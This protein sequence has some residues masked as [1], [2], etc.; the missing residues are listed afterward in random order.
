MTTNTQVNKAITST[1]TAGAIPLWDANLNLSANNYL[2]GYTTTATAAGTTTLTIASTYQQFFTGSTT[3]TVTLPVTSTLVLG[4]SF[5]IVNNSSGNV[6]VNSSGGNAIQVMGANTTLLVT[7]ILTSG[8]T[9]ASWSIEYVGE[10]SG[11]TVGSGTIN[12]LA[13]YSATGTTV[14]GLTIVNSAGL[15]TNGSGVPAWV[16]YTGT[17]AP[18]LNTSPKL[19]T[20]ILDT[21]GNTI[22]GLGPVASAVNY[23]Q[24]Q[25]GA[26]GNAVSVNALGSDSNIVLSISGKGTSGAQVQG[27]SGA[28]ANSAGYIGEVISSV[29]ASGSAV[30]LT[31]VTAANVTSISLTAGDWD[32]WGNVFINDNATTLLVMYGWIS[33]TSAT[34]PDVSLVNGYYGGLLNFNGFSVPSIRINV[35]TTTTVYLGAYANFASGAVTACG[36][37]FARRAG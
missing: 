8:T 4:F 3:Q 11:G 22:I 7:C 1:P 12:Q 28:G 20:S 14:V 9:A 26:T 16:A 2:S 6:T 35:S 34:V 19:I 30:S 23:L 32:V 27:K 33:T 36:G 21:N 15:L 10:A 24:L 25:N 29:I 37:I 18:V 31:T 13:W 5:Y 17:G